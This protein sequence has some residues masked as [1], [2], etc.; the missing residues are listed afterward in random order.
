MFSRIFS[1]QRHRDSSQRHREDT[2]FDRTLKGREKF[3]RRYE[4]R[5][6]LADFSMRALR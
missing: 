5:D 2:F 4:A 1:P 6:L 3:K